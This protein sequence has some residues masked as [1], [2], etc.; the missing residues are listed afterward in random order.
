MNILIT[1]LLIFAPINEYTGKY[2]QVIDVNSST[3]YWTH[4]KFHRDRRAFQEKEQP[5]QRMK[6]G[7]HLT[8]LQNLVQHTY[9]NW[10]E[11]RGR[12]V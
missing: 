9:R 7:K 8:V 6:V 11:R 5:G 12:P 2:L 1:Y 3:K 4:K 10:L